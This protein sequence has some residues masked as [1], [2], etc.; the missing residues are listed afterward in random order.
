MASTNTPYNKAR[1]TFMDGSALN[2]TDTIKGMLVS[3]AYTPNYD[4]HQY[5]SDVTNELSTA[6]G[7]TAGGATLGSKTWSLVGTG[8]AGKYVLQS[9]AIQW[10][11]SGGSITA[12]YLIL[13]KD[14]GTASTSPLLC[15]I[16]I[17]NTP[18]DV[19]AT[20]G[21][22]FTVTPDATNGWFYC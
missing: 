8:A 18:A 1:L 6:N 13:Y 2:V 19:T 9:S 21:N 10:T 22:P 20:S 4:T 15:C 16:L 3:S 7:Y 12:R 5:K 17:D 14:T 11:A